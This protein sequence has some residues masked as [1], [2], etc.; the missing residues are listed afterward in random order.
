MKIKIKCSRKKE[1]N[2]LGRKFDN[3]NKHDN[4]VKLTRLVFWRPCNCK[5]NMHYQQKRAR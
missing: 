3:L 5:N 4:K 2:F 1:A